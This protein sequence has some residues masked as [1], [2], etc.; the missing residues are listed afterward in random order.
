M[1]SFTPT[2]EQQM[3]VDSVR[4]YATDQAR[5]AAH[6]ADE[7]GTMAPDVIRKGWNL[8][9]L[10]GLIPDT[11]GGYAEGP[12]AV[13]GV[14]ALE[15]LACGDLSTALE[16]WAPALFALPI[17]FSGTEAQKQEYLPAFCD[18]ARPLMSAALIEPRV[19]FDPRRPATVAARSGGDFVLNGEKAYVPLAAEAERLI[20]YARDSETGAVNGF[21]VDQG[22]EGLVVGDREQLMGVKAVPLYRLGLSNVTVSPDRV[23]GGESGTAYDTIL[24]RS[25][26]AL[27]AMA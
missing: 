3:L 13:T 14:L 24:N 4:R 25:A 22:A 6:E 10:P 17:L 9:I 7:T 2:D 8:G 5:R 12:A 15:E 27:G 16:L 18:A 23:V 21:I 20:I 26:I 1:Y 19:L 11:Y